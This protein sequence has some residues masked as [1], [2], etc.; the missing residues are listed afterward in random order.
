MPH[1]LISNVI[2]ST[3]ETSPGISISRNNIRNMKLEIAKENTIAPIIIASTT[4]I[5]STTIAMPYPSLLGQGVLRS[6][7]VFRLQLITSQI[8]GA[9]KMVY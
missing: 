3:K 1:G 2:R 4:P 5:A 9:S 6:D 8:W 7:W